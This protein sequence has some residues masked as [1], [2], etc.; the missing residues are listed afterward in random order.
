MKPVGVTGDRLG[1]TGRPYL[2]RYQ[3]LPLEVS[4]GVEQIYVARVSSTLLRQLSFRIETER[5]MLAN[6]RVVLTGFA[7]Y[8]GLVALILALN[9]V[10]FLYYRS[11]VPIL[12]GFIVIFFFAYQAAL[13]GFFYEYM[14]WLPPAAQDRSYYLVTGTAIALMA[15]FAEKTLLMRIHVPRLSR[16]LWPFR[17]L[18]FGMILGVL[19]PDRFL[20]ALNS[21]GLAVFA[22]F[23]L[24][25]IVVALVTARRGFL[26]AIFSGIGISIWV[27]SIG[28]VLLADLGLYQHGLLTRFTPLAGSFLD[29]VFFLAAL[30]ARVRLLV[31]YSGGAGFWSEKN[32]VER[33]GE[34]QIR[35]KKSKL[36]G[37]PVTSL[38]SELHRLMDVEKLYRDGDLTLTALGERLGISAQQM[39]E[40]LNSREQCN[41]FHYVNK[42]RIQ[43]A[44]ELIRADPKRTVLSIA[45]DVGFNSK[46]SFNTEFKRVHGV[47]PTQFRTRKTADS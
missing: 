6:D 43:E 25:L 45:M 12:Y 8:A 14:P 31:P 11:A 13:D 22:V 37:L 18:A 7:V 46:S 21:Y 9:L 4:P 38:V 41:F 32:A 23:V 20:N 10:S 16:L 19:L 47:T 24:Y 35:Y 3:I 17:F 29:M 26:P 33:Y 2:H 44:A 27:G 30:F 42:F 36:S 1:Y 40:L 34:E 15:F 39:S 5:T 28:L